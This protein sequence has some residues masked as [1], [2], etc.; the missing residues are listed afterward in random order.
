MYNYII[1]TTKKCM[2]Q[3]KNKIERTKDKAKTI[4]MSWLY[5]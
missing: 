1:M 4:L 5:L 3:K 2:S